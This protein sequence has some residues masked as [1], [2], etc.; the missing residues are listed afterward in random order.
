MTQ[1]RKRPDLAQRNRENSK[2][3]CYGV[4]I[5]GVDRRIYKIWKNIKSR[6]FNSD[7]KD[8]KNYGKR[9]IRVCKEWLNDFMSFYNWAVS[10]SYSEELTI[11]RIDF[12]GDYEPPNC[13]WANPKQ[14]AR[15]RRN[16]R[17]ITYN[18]ETHCI[19][20]WAEIVNIPRKCLEY[21]LRN[22]DDLDRV[23]NRPVTK[24][25]KI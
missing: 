18:N 5:K 3:L 6:C 22:W 21:R 2:Y 23:F 8:Y 7:D 9:G 24:N 11:D 16:N 15:N 4:D 13:R 25:N 20:E 10:N 14:Q 19:A 1:K 12:N 17:Y